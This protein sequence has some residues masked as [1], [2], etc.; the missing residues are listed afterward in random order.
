[1]LSRNTTQDTTF[2]VWIRRVS[3]WDYFRNHGAGSGF[4]SPDA[5]TPR[6]STIRTF[7]MPG[8][9]GRN[10]LPEGIA[11]CWVDDI[12]DSGLAES[13]FEMRVLPT[14]GYDTSRAVRTFGIT[15]D[16][17]CLR[18]Q[19]TP[20]NIVKVAQ[21]GDLNNTC[22]CSSKS[23]VEVTPHEGYTPL[24]P[25]QGGLNRPAV[26]YGDI[27]TYGQSSL[28]WTTDSTNYCPDSPYQKPGS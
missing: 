14:P 5:G 21:G 13:R 10:G 27:P 28:K 22:V 8:G 7:T 19:S 11:V 25:G 17:N 2:R 18:P 23:L 12:I 3:G 4:Y 16:D 20:G 9:Q 26:V 15:E 1:V 6:T 24:T